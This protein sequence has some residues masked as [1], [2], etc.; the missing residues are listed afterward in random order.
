M[1]D[2]AI[3]ATAAAPALGWSEDHFIKTYT[4]N[5]EQA[6]ESALDASPVAAVIRTLA[7]SGDWAG[8]AAELLEAVTKLVDDVTKRA[9]SWPDSP[10]RLGSALRR[11]TPNLR[12]VGVQVEF[13][14]RRAL[15]PRRRQITIT[16]T[17]PPPDGDQK[18]EAIHRSDR[19]DG[20]YAG[21]QD[22][23]AF[24]GR[25]DRSGGNDV[26]NDESPHGNK[27][28]DGN[29]VAAVLSADDEVEL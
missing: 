2:F 4:A 15:G 11:L 28:N 9:R 7:D 19:S 14:D 3:W 23:L 25:I 6:H 8:T 1:A 29:D 16:K 17:A 22:G 21:L 12:A 10:R 26:G 24:P 13:S 20:S 27:G 18:E 5:R